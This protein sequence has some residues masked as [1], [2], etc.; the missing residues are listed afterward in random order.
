MR[1]I[2]IKFFPHSTTFDNEAGIST[3]Q[4]DT[5]LSPLGKEQVINL[6]FATFNENFHVVFCSDLIR[7][8]KT[9]EGA[10][11]GRFPI[12]IDK[13]LREIDVGSMTGE[14]NSVTGSLTE[15]FISVPF[16]DG[17]SFEDVEKRI[18][19]FLDNYL[20]ELVDKKIAIIGHQATQLA[21]EVITKKIS[22]KEAIKGDWRNKRSFQYGWE[23]IFYFK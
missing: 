2:Y 22:W 6:R 16:P 4:A 20:N 17:E 9:A 5:D 11:G 10:F 1:S 12:I 21:L 13:K 15:K 7:A 23:Y 19:E 14:K 3:G 8:I 18:R